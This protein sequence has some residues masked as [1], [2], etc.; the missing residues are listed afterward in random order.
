MHSLQTLDQKGFTDRD[1]FGKVQRL[2]KA[3]IS[4]GPENANVPFG[5]YK[6]T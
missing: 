2:I 1:M 4:L 5:V 6:W 3:T